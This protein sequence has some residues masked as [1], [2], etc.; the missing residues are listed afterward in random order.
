MPSIVADLTRRVHQ[1]NLKFM[2]KQVKVDPK[3]PLML[4]RNEMQNIV[5]GSITETVI[6]AVLS[7]MEYFYRMGIREA[8]RMKAQL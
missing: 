3:R 4:S 5:G 8:K 1:F 7:G 6:K 2:E